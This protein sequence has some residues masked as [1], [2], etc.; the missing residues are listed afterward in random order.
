MLNYDKTVLYKKLIKDLNTD[1]RLA[2]ALLKTMANLDERLQEPL[3]NW[4]AGKNAD[5]YCFDGIS[6]AVIQFRFRYNFIDSLYQMD[7]F[8][9]DD[10]D[11][12]LFKEEMTKP[13]LLD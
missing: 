5:D 2:K 9:K 4:L 12:E 3:D 1:E 6:L 7:S 11:R 10:K 8:M 13:L